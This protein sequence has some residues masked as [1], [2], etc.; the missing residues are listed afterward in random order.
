MKRQKIQMLVLLALFVA[1]AAAYFGIRQYKLRQEEKEEDVERTPIAEVLPEE[2]IRFSFDHEGENYTFEKEDGVWYYAEDHSIA[3]KQDRLDLIL[4]Y[5]VPVAAEQVIS[6]VEDLSLYGLAEPSGTF[7]YE[8]ASESYVY[9]VGDSNELTSSC[10][11]CVP[12]GTDVYVVD[13]QDI[14]RLNIS[15]E[16]LTETET[17]ETEDSSAT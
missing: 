14:S 12:G 9:N 5:I 7:S 16:E 10:Y 13:Q 4:N 17:S 2:I 6:D 3:I 11:V 8:T 1:L 15:L